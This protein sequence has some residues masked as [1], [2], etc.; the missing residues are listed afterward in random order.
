[1]AL[2]R[3]GAVLLHPTSLP[4]GH[5]CGDFGPA[6]FAF[7]DYLARCKMGGWQILPLGPTGPEGS[8]YQAASSFAGNPLLLSLQKLADAGLLTPADLAGAETLN[9]G[10]IRFPDVRAYK[11]ARLRS[12]FTNFKNGLASTT[13]T[14]SFARF[15]K[16]QSPW[17]E[18]YALFAALKAHYQNAAWWQWEEGLASRQSTALKQWREKLAPEIEFQSWL[19]FAFYVQ[20]GELKKYANAAGIR[21]IGD[22]PIYT[23]HDSADVWAAREYFE[24]DPKTGEALRMAGAPPDYFCEDGQLWGNPIY[25][26]ERLKADGFAWWIKRMRAV[27][28]MCDVVRIDHFRGFEAY[29]DT[30]AGEKT[31]R[32]GTWKPGPGQPFFDALR[33]A[34]G[35]DLP[36]IAEDLGVITPAVDKLR[37]DNGLPGMKILQFAFCDGANAYRPHSYDKNCVVY[38]GTHDNDT[39]RGWYAAQGPDYAHMNRATIDAERDLCRR[40]LSADGSNIHWDLIKLALASVADTAVIPMQDILGLGNESRMN[41]PGTA[42]GCWGW[43][44]SMEQLQTADSGY[45]ALMNEVYDRAP[46]TITN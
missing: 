32:N 1:M 36:L 9:A 37:T 43:R 25:K 7:V 42:E 2:P 17:L 28:T 5:G 18:D 11:F 33:K 3:S 12:A 35:D 16:D 20:W 6:A 23:A 21:I 27:L 40:Y 45:L 34:L 4:G 41:V 10:R 39:T 44:M 13:A 29:W 24:V 15:C 31:A 8:P 38:T 14:E 30:P 22:I 19:Q 26:W 46:Q